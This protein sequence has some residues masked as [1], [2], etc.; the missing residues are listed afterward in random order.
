MS[1]FNRTAMFI[2]LVLVIAWSMSKFDGKIYLREKF[3]W[4]HRCQLEWK[5]PFGILRERYLVCIETGEKVGYYYESDGLWKAY[6]SG[7]LFKDFVEEEQA[8]LA[9]EKCQ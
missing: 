1:K 9:V 2:W 8:K 5:G 7:C 4:F 6:V 3:H